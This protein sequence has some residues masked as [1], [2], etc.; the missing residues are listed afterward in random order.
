MIDLQT[1]YIGFRLSLGTA[2]TE[3]PGQANWICPGV[4]G[5]Q[6]LDQRIYSILGSHP[7]EINAQGCAAFDKHKTEL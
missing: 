6:V 4:L 5:G 3:E 2:D 1:I 7:L